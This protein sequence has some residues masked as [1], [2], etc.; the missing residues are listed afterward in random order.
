MEFVFDRTASDVINAKKIK[1]EKFL[2]GIA[3]SNNEKITIKKGSLSL[4]DINR[5]EQNLYDIQT[6]MIDI[7]YY[8]QMQKNFDIFNQESVFYK[9]QILDWVERVEALKKGF[10]PYNDTPSEPVAMYHYEEINKI[11]KILFDMHKRLKEIKSFFRECGNFE[12][13]G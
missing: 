12:C 2:N 7:G 10:F 13:G 5:I 8:I 3:L 9:Y 6:D 11:E 1:Q 4:E